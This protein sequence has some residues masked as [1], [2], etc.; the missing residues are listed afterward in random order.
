MSRVPKGK[1]EIEY[2]ETGANERLEIQLRASF[3][4]KG[5]GDIDEVRSAL[6]GALSLCGDVEE[7]Q[8][9]ALSASTVLN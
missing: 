5:E 7:I 3:R 6:H 1:I 2:F 8:N 4:E 9:H